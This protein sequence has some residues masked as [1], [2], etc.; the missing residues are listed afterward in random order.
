MSANRAAMRRIFER[1]RPG[2][3]F[4]AAAHKHVPLM[5]A[6][7]REAVKNNVVGTRTSPTLAD[8]AWR[9][10]VRPRV[11][12]QGGEP[13]VVMGATKRV[14]EIYVQ[15][16]SQRAGR[17]FVHRPLR[18]RP[19]LAPAASSRSSASRSPGR[20]GDGHAP[21]DDALLHDDPGGG[22]SS[23]SRR[24]R[25]ARRRDLRPR[26]GRAGEDRRPRPRPHPA[27]GNGAR[28]RHRDRVHRR[29]AGGEA[30]RGA[31]ERGRA[32]RPH[33][34]PEDP[35]APR[36]GRST[37]G[38]SRRSSRSSSVWPIWGRRSRSSPG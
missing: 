29:P 30:L 20:P 5:E 31:L 19:R 9:E 35:L 22:A 32:G 6:N 4:H 8:R 21:R 14:A 12:G 24:A 37:R 11:D 2:V 7:P 28:R 13:D 16:L 3:V 25:W 38:G 18:K 1:E 34:A 27:L 26:H 33:P 36:T 17:S 10:A 23:S 15:A